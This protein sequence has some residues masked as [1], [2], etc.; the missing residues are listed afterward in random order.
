M[1]TLS[2]VTVIDMSKEDLDRTITQIEKNL[3]YMD[4]VSRHIPCP[5]LLYS[6]D[7]RVVW[8]NKAML[9]LFWGTL[10]APSYTNPS[11]VFGKRVQDIM[12]DYLW[13]YVLQENDKVFKSQTSQYE[14]WSDEVW[15]SLKWKCLR[16][17]VDDNHVGVVLFPENE[18]HLK[19]CDEAVRLN[20]DGS[21]SNTYKP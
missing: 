2:N 20:K 5:V 8:C 12:P 15:V 6:R 16:F 13:P 18:E 19:L 3:N 11:N 14:T 1:T 21:R 10:A 9:N 7:G 17:P 4:M